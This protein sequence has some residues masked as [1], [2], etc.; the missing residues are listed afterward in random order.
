MYN[1]AISHVKLD[2]TLEALVLLEKVLEF[3]RRV[4]PEDHPDIGE[5]AG[6]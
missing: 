5:F 2:R 3:F 4:L 6:L 1:L